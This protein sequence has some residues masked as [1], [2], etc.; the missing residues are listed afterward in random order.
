[1]KLRVVLEREIDGGVGGATTL[2]VTVTAWGLFDAPTPVMEIVPVYVLGAS[3]DGLTETVS[4]PD[5]A[6]MLIQDAPELADHVNIPP[7]ELD[8]LTVWDAGTALPA[9]YENRSCAGDS[10]TVG[11]ACA[12]MLIESVPDADCTTNWTSWLLKVAGRNAAIA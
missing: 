4:V 8:T 7:P 3:P 9:V 12:M 6:A 1:M 11:E 10:E 2:S 5:A